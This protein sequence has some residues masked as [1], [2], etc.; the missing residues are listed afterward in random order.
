ME[1][2]RV[3]MLVVMMLVMGNMLIEAE[4]VMSFKLCYGGCLV[5]CALI[6]PPIKKLFCP[7]LCIKDCKRRPMLSF[8]ANLNEIDQ[9]GS[10]CELGCA[11]D[12]CVSSSSIDDKDHVEKVSL[13]V[14]SCSEECS[15]K[16]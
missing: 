8:E 1:D 15:H 10:Y 5:A 6:A 3:A 2:K 12:R 13:C 4:A 14:D 11:T 9:T 7:F 16:N